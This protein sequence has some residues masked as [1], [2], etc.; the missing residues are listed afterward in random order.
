M[1]EK[2]GDHKEVFSLLVR[3]AEL[4][5][6]GAAIRDK[7]HAAAAVAREK[8]GD[9][10]KAIDLYGQI[11]EDEPSDTKASTALRGLYAKVGKHKELLALLSRLIDLAEKPAERTTLRLE[12]RR[13]SASTSSTP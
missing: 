11:F 4:V 10:A 1:R 8:L 9:D 7:S 13:R 2:A 12:S 3:Q 6:D 5:A